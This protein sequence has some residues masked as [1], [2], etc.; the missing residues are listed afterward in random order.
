MAIKNKGDFIFDAFKF[1]NSFIHK[2]ADTII[3]I[4]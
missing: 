4:K 3:Q 1:L 2:K